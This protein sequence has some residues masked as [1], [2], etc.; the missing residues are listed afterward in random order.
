MLSDLHNSL[1]F[2]LFYACLLA[3]IIGSVYGQSYFISKVV[4]PE[5]INW[6]RITSITQDRQGFMWF[7]GEGL[8]RYDGYKLTAFRNEPLNP[9]SLSFHKAEAVFCDRQGTIWVGTSGGGLDQFDPA[10]GSFTH[11]RHDPTNSQSISDDHITALVEDRYG[12]FWVGT[13]GG[14]NRMDRRTGRFTAYKHDPANPNSLSNNEVRVVYEDRQ[15]I[16]WIGTGSPF[17]ETRL[18]DGGLNRF[19]LKTN[20][21][22]RYLHQSTNPHSLANN[23]VRAIYEDSRGTFWVGT[24]GDGLHTLDRQTGSFTRYPYDPKHPEKLSRPYLKNGVITPND[25]VTFVQ[26]DATG[27][28]WIGAYLNGLNRYDPVHKTIQHFEAE[29][30]NPNA[31][32]ENGPWAFY[33]S[34]DGVHWV[35]TWDGGLYR[36]VSK[37]NL[38]PFASTGAEVMAFCQDNA[39]RLWVGTEQGLYQHNLM[40]GRKERFIHDSLNPASLRDSDVRE[41]YQDRQGTIW[42]GTRGGGLHRFNETTHSFD[43][44]RHDPKKSNSLID[45]NVQLIKE[46]RYGKLWLGTPFGLDEFNPKTGEFIH[47]RA[48]ALDPH[49]LSDNAIPVLIEDHL[50]FIWAGGYFVGGVSRFDYKTRTFRRYLPKCRVTGMEED[51][52]GVVW[53]AGPEGLFRYDRTKDRF[54]EIPAFRPNSFMINSLQIDDQNNLWLGNWTNLT[55]Y[56]PLHNKLTRFGKFHGVEG[57]IRAF[58]SYKAP[59]GKLFFGN[60]WGYYSFYP[61][62]IKPKNRPADVL[63]TAI[64]VHDKPLLTRPNSPLTEPLD[65]TKQIT[66]DYRQNVLAFD[67]A[68]IDYR[69]PD[70]NRHLFMLE[71]YDATW[72]QAGL[73]RTVSYI[74]VPPG[75]YVFRVKG[76]SNN[77][78]WVEKRLT[79]IINPP[80]WQTWWAYTLYTLLAITA[81]WAIIYYR[82]QALRRKNRELEEQVSLRTQELTQSL[83]NL[84][85]T[86]NQL[87]QKEKLASLGELTAGIAHEIQNPLNFVNNFAEVSVEL[88]DELHQSVEEGDKPLSQELANDLRQN[89]TQIELNGKR[90]SNIVRAMLEHS[91]ASSGER[92]PTDLNTLAEE[93]LRLAYHGFR[94]KHSDF[95]ATLKT[96]F[97]ADLPQV[98]MVAGDVGRVLLNLYNNAFYALQQRQLQETADYEPT[99]WVSTNRVGGAVEVRVKDNGLGIPAS[100]R[101][102]VFQ[103]FFTTKPT[104]QGTGLGLSL[105]YDI[106]TKGHGGEMWVE[107][108]EGQ[109]TTFFLTLP[110]HY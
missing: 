71:K 109:G 40:T 21:F 66:L 85:T 42:V 96:D 31:M 2:R 9:R 39:G 62:R 6:G 34:R 106:I 61:D 98:E 88:A 35:S 12:N 50:G 91:S 54:S 47:H 32:Q 63:I 57:H 86:Q 10:T 79:I 33:T 43:N 45:D 52:N 24:F 101:E 92:Q 87:I 37:Q 18:G 110:A 29:S 97:S 15:G 68:C 60:Q 53:I 49:T 65:R 104:G 38:F 77:G 75:Q 67:F 76:S 51:K 44:Y 93:Y 16:L 5:D 20:T 102:K 36:F 17:G 41:I 69:N 84:K 4:T 64:R 99:I 56:E 8:Y 7:V 28:L 80:W 82:S 27:N 107:S 58:S 72:R 46:D 48:N 55:K 11:Y 83:A 89:M 78:P 73:E 22:T 94:S 103:P 59:D 70:E 19:N 100:I 81:I 26:E 23:M 1:Q 25:G 14:L 95:T 105:S 108:G 3:L 30:N 90:A 74:N 13:H